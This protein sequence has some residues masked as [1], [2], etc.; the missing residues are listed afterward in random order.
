M[1]KIKVII[2]EPFKVPYVSK[3]D[4]TLEALQ[5]IVEGYIET[6]TVNQDMVIICDE[7]GLLKDNHFNCR[8]LNIQF[9]GTIIFAGVNGDEF[10]DLPISEE[11]FKKLFP[12][13]YS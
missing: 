7:E 2:K 3:I 11:E 5:K 1:S 13:L 4:N 12:R 6:V 8:V 10:S 9:F